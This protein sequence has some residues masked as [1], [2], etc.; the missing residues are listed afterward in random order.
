MGMIGTVTS[1]G[2]TTIP[3]QV[4]EKLGL[5]QGT[6]IEWVLDDE[7]VIVKARKLKV[8]DL[9]GML[10]EPPAGKGSNLKEIDATVRK[11]VARHVLGEDT[12][13]DE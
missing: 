3:K 12:A 10:G 4:R 2:Q 13:D 5:D 9:F 8:T 6:R 1:K 7:K 11:A